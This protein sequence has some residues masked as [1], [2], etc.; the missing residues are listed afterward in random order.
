MKRIVLN[1]KNLV[2]DDS[3]LNFRK[4]R[5]IIEN[6]VG[7]IIVSNEGGICIFPG[8][9]CDGDEP[10][11]LAIKR[12][13]EEETGIKLTSD[14]MEKVLEI[15][16][17]Y[18]DFYDFRSDSIKPRHMLTT[19]FHVKTEKKIDTN[20]LKLTPS[21]EKLGFNVFT[22]GKNNLYKLLNEHHSNIRNGKFFDEEN[23]VVLEEIFMKKKH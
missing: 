10:E 15:E 12:E 23:K 8:G 22:T 20:K 17:F 2:Q 4:V 6:N 9:K 13:I 1:D 16:A 21:E 18:D 19:Y 3:W 14:V 7:E 5:A 11:E